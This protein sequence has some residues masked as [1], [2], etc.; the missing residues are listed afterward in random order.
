M[1]KLD[2]HVHSEY[3]EDA[4]GSVK[5]IMRS[6]QQ[7]GLHGCAITDH[8][9]VKG[10]MEAKKLSSKEFLIIPGVEISTRDGHLIAL[11]VTE[12][13]QRGLPV[14]ETVDLIKKAS[15][16]PIVPHVFRNMSGIK[17]SKLKKV[18]PSLSSIEVF[19]SCS[20]P[21]TNMK[22][23]KLAQSMN[24]GGTGGSDSHIPE[25]AGYGYTVVETDDLTLDAVISAIEK[26][27]TW[28]KGQSL[29]FS[30][31]QD[32]MVKSIRQFFQRGLRKI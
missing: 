31:R 18:R 24:L 14:E 25:Y 16:V 4:I 32:R 19:N 29:P 15:G 1:L 8:N 11:N 13:I 20:Q 3:S 23:A 2:L 6:L 10:A 27:K 28:G 5:E 9:T 26:K 22:I 12:D 7:K 30:Y 17:L 21:S